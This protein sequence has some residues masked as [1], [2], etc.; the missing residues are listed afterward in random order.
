VLHA[1]REQ[2]ISLE[3]GRVLASGIPGVRFVTM[4]GRN[5][6]LVDYEPVWKTCWPRSVFR[7]AKLTPL[8]G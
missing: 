2:R 3:Q 6:V 8:A 7:R 5:H 4:G 1:R